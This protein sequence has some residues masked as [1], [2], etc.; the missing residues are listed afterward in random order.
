M[1]ALGRVELCG[2]C[3]RRPGCYWPRQF[4]KGL[5]GA[6]VIFGTDAHL[7]RSPDFAAQLAGWA[8]AGA[9]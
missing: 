1:A 4:G 3:P 8:G 6:Q 5:E 7:G 9:S 2:R